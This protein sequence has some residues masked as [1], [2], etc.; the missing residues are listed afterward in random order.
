MQ[1]KSIENRGMSRNLIF[2]VTAVIENET[3]YCQNVVC[4]EVWFFVSWISKT[5]SCK[6]CCE[7]C[8]SAAFK[9]GV[10]ISAHK[11]VAQRVFFFQKQQNSWIGFERKACSASDDFSKIFPDAKCFQQRLTCRSRLVG[12]GT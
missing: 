3:S 7:P 8:S 5:V 10:M 2:F 4:D 1:Q 6:N 9:I 12:R 11:V